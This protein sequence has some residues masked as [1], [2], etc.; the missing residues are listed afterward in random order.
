MGDRNYLLISLL[1]CLNILGIIIV[2]LGL[3][4]IRF[5]AELS[6]LIVIFIIFII[7]LYGLIEDRPWACLTAT[8]SFAVNLANTFVLY[9]MQDD[10]LPTVSALLLLNAV[11]FALAVSS[12][13]SRR[14]CTARR[15]DDIEIEEIKPMTIETYE[16]RPDKAEA[17]SEV[18]KNYSPG[19]Y[20]GSVLGNKYHSPKCDFAKKIPKQNRIWFTAE[21]DAK[22][23]G[24]M[25]CK[26][27]E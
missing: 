18:T 24:Y 1:E 3:S 20:I 16:I 10:I 19:K 17:R 26:C 7:T 9:L 11:G 23:Q 6:I 2:L 14:V 22:K 12:M 4:S 27:L 25:P 13:C 15:A 8:A 5:V 21:T